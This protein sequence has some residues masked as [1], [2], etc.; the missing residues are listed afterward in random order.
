V[1]N[2]AGEDWLESQQSGQPEQSEMESCIA[3]YQRPSVAISC[4]L[5]HLAKQLLQ[6]ADITN[7]CAAHRQLSATLFDPLPQIKDFR[8]CI[9]IQRCHDG[10]AVPM[11]ADE[12][13]AF[14]ADQGFPHGPL[15]AAELR[16]ERQL[17]QDSAGHELVHH[18]LAAQICK[19]SGASRC[20]QTSRQSFLDLVLIMATTAPVIWQP[21]KCAWPRLSHVALKRLVGAREESSPTSQAG[22]RVRGR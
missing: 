8:G 5:V 6:P 2:A 22:Y 20:V 14:Q 19:H 7:A 15:A 17:R 12:A 4:I 16:G 9:P 11:A 18:D 10:P 21:R 13:F 3:F 1:Q